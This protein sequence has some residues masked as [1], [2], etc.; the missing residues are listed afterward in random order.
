MLLIK[1]KEPRFISRFLFCLLNLP[2]INKTI[3]F[4]QD[5]MYYIY[6]DKAFFLVIF[7]YI[8]INF[9]VLYIVE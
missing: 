6:C 4:L 7:L 2:S 5:F 8:L 3:G 9:N 1:N